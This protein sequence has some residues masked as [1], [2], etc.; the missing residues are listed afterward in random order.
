MSGHGAVKTQP[1]IIADTELQSIAIIYCLRSPNAIIIPTLWLCG[2]VSKR[3]Y[4]GPLLLIYQTAQIKP[5]L[6]TLSVSS[7]MTKARYWP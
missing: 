6:Q 7:S 5:T 2:T 4:T 3:F 1:V